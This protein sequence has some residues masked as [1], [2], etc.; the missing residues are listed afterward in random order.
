MREHGGSDDGRILDLH[1]VM[2]LV[3]LLETAQDGD[4]VLDAWL[5]DVHR[6]E[7]PLERCILLDVLLI[8]IQSRGPYGAQLAAGQSRLQDVGGIHG[9]L[10]RSGADDRMQ[11]VDEEDHVAFRFLDLFNDCLEPVF[12]FSAVLRAGDHGAEIERYD[13]LVLKAFRN[14]PLDDPPGQTFDDG[15]LADA[16]LADQ[17]RIVLRPARQDLNDAPDLLVPSDHRIELAAARQ[18]RQIAR[19]SFQ[20]L[21]LVLRILV[22]HP[23]RAAN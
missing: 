7:A 16:R 19:V 9:P 21:V 23:L 17:H 18:R 13:A 1:A 6:L 10:R 20:G 14:V 11:L 3:A 5:T 8:L 2:N 22:R 12:E 4:G 15:R